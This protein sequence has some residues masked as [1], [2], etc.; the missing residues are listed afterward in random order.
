MSRTQIVRDENRAMQLAEQYRPFIY[1]EWK[2]RRDFITPM[3]FMN[4]QTIYQQLHIYTKQPTLY[5]LIRESNSIAKSQGDN[6]L[7]AFY[8]VFHPFDWSDS[9]LLP[10]K[11]A[12]THN[13]DTESLC[14][15]HNL[16]TNRMDVATVFHYRIKFGKDIRD[17]R[18]FIQSEGH[19][20]LPYKDGLLNRADMVM[21]YFNYRFV[22]LQVV[23]SQQWIKIKQYLGEHAKIPHEQADTFWLYHQGSKTRH[24]PGQMFLEPDQLFKKAEEVKYI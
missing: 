1:Q 10:L 2:D 4:K 11:M 22:D 21:A 14:F 18:I 3:T 23:R 17:R 5:F 13:F 9:K 12:E 15:R 20:I 16:D 7:Y 6:Y 19:G 8:L 24:T